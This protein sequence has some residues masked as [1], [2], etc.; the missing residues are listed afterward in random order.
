MG[1]VVDN[2]AE[3]VDICRSENLETTDVNSLDGYLRAHVFDPLG[4]RLEFME[5]M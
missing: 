5:P 2:V 3:L 4:N 1:F